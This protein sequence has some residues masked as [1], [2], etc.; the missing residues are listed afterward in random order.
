MLTQADLDPGWVLGDPVE[1]RTC[2]QDRPQQKPDSCVGH[3]LLTWAVFFA[4]TGL[5]KAC[6]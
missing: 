3:L 2:T 5:L 4:T 1:P 6:S